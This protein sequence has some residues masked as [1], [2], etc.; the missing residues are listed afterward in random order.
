MF[1]AIALRNL[2]IRE[3]SFSNFFHL[4]PSKFGRPIRLTRKYFISI[5]SFFEHVIG[6]IRRATKK[7]MG[8]SY[9]TPIITMMANQNSRWNHSILKFPRISV[10]EL[11]LPIR[12]LADSDS[13]IAIFHFSLGVIPT[14]FGLLNVF[15][16]F[17][18]GAI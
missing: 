7:Q 14:V 1:N 16:E 9:A 2:L 11:I 13:G 3:L 12:T 17:H 18:W 4:S 8:W 10:C 5:T 6:I 15:P